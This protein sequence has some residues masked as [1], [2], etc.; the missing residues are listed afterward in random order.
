MEIFPLCLNPELRWIFYFTVR[1]VEYRI[2]ARRM[3][4]P[5]SSRLNRTF[6]C[7]DLEFDQLEVYNAY[8]RHKQLCHWER[9]IF[10]KGSYDMTD[11]SFGEDSSIPWTTLK[12][13]FLKLNDKDLS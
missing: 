9:W 12:I 7:E 5:H 3:Y 10:Q 2:F 8:K 11:V 4:G 1:T 6:Y 13:T